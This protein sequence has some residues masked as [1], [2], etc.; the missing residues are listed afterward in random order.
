MDKLSLLLE[1]KEEPIVLLDFPN[2][3]QGTRYYCGVDC[4]ET[5]LAY[6][7]ID[8][9]EQDLAT[10]LDADPKNGTSIERMVKFISMQRGLQV[11]YRQN[12]TINDLKKYLNKKIPV[13]V[14]IQAWPSKDV[15]DW[16]DEWNS[17]HY[18]VA[19]GYTD[20]KILFGDPATYYEVS[21]I[22]NGEFMKRWH[23]EDR[24]K[25]YEQFGCAVFGRKPKYD[26]N[27]WKKID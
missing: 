25:K 15:K 4:V 26:K 13:I 8:V 24:D 27:K 17:G 16:E 12:M 2:Q 14:M 23:D 18:V 10:I 11:E 5:V 9:R 6:Y 3:R 22:E 1:Q 19:I 21:Y 20:T 7:D